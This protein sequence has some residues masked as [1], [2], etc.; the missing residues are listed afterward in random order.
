MG[1]NTLGG[2]VATRLTIALLCCAC[3]FETAPLSRQG[4]LAPTRQ[5]GST[6]EPAPFDNPA[7][8]APPNAAASAPMQPAAAGASTGSA[9]SV[10]AG[11][12]PQGAAGQGGAQE[13]TPGTNPDPDPDPEPD[14][15]PDADPTDPPVESDAASPDA[16]PDAGPTGPAPGAVFSGCLQNTDC[17]SGLVCTTTLAALSGTQIE[18]G[19]CAA[20]CNWTTPNP[21]QCPQPTSGLVRSSCLPGT[22]LCV[23]GS[24]ERSV[25][26]TEMECVEV[27]TPLG[28][29]QVRTDFTCQP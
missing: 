2:A 15:D 3:H 6:A 13:P 16:A 18:I 7:A 28:A 19:Y 23:L 21:D 25:C 24:C 26:P 27:V 22:T 14:P 9:G 1:M 20:L 11:S 4:D 12:G 8:N 5:G 29:G 17:D 10:S